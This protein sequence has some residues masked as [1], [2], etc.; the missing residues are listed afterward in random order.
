M[1]KTLISLLYLFV[2][3]FLFSEGF[4]LSPNISLKNGTAKEYV[5]A[6]DYKVSQ[7]D[8]QVENQV[9]LG[10]DVDFEFKKY[11]FRLGFSTEVATFG[12]IMED[13]DWLDESAQ[14]DITRYSCDD[15]LVSKDN[16]FSLD[17]GFLFDF[18][19][20]NFGKLI[21]QLHVLDS[22]YYGLNGW[23]YYKDWEPYGKAEGTLS[24]TV[25][26]Y[27]PY[28]TS[29][30]VGFGAKTYF[31]E[32]AFINFEGYLG[33]ASGVCTDVHVERNMVFQDCVSGFFLVKNDICLGYDFSE[34]STLILGG[35]LENTPILE[36][37]TYINEYPTNG[38]TGGFSSFFYEFYLSYRIRML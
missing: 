38:G 32:N 27:N 9:D 7:L 16:S 25:I 31:V 22:E 4:Y 30:Y 20:K 28:L 26:T 1:K 8:W 19:K 36:G 12:G 34:K 24:G 21:F 35:K 29:F 14:D 5:F 17:F 6:G 10:I 3:F 11:F 18:S 2:G 15:L 23:Y 13:Y 37:V 33:Y